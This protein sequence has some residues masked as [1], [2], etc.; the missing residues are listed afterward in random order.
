[1]TRLAKAIRFFEKGGMSLLA[2]NKRLHIDRDVLRRE[3]RKRYG[4]E[5]FEQMW[6]ERQGKWYSKAMLK[7]IDAEIEHGELCLR[8]IERKFHTHSVALYRNMQRYYGQERWAEIFE[9]YKEQR[10]FRKGSQIGKE[11]QFKKGAA[12]RWVNARRWRSIGSIQY[13]KCQYGPYKKKFWMV[14]F[15]KISDVPN[16]KNWTTY[17]RWLWI[18]KYGPIPKGKFVI[19]LDN[20]RENDDLENNLALMTRKEHAQYRDARFP[21]LLEQRRR[22][23]VSAAKKNVRTPA[24]YSRLWQCTECAGEFEQKLERCPKCGSYSIE[25]VRIKVA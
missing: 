5:V 15:I 23:L 24:R 4:D 16:G 20:N 10:G 2:I 17:A 12:L 6:R 14:K 3:L 22:R 1:M 18:Q 13:K 21:K 9:Y 11:Y 19:H 25:Q 7:A 8:K